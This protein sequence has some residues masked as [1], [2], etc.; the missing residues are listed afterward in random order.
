MINLNLIRHPRMPGNKKE[1]ENREGHEG[2]RSR[3]NP[4]EKLHLGR[5]KTED[6]DSDVVI[7]GHNF[8]FSHQF[9]NYLHSDPAAKNLT[10]CGKIFLLEA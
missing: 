5:Y 7:L 2:I 10:K 9:Q 8:H 6:Q 1:T 3:L 4:F